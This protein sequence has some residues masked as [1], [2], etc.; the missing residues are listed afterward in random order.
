MDKFD[1]L[2]TTLSS[3]PPSSSETGISSEHSVEIYRSIIQHVDDYISFVDRDYRYLAVS[4]G[5]VNL[6]GRAEADIVGR[7]VWEL[8]GRERFETGLKPHLD[9]T[10]NRGEI[11]KFRAQIVSAQGE[12]RQIETEFVPYRNS[13]GEITGVVVCARNVTR[14]YQA[15][16]ALKKESTLSQLIIDSTPDFVFFKDING[17]YQRCNDAFQRFVCLPEQDIIGRSD[18]DLMQEESANHIRQRDQQVLV[19]KEVCENEEWVTYHNSRRRLLNMTKIPVFDDAQ[20]LIGLLGIGRDITQE[21]QG[22]S[23][24]A[25]AALLFQVTSDPCLILAPDGIIVDANPVSY[26]I[27]GYEANS[28]IGLPADC[29][30]H[31]S[32]GQPSL[33]T[34]LSRRSWKGEMIGILGSGESKPFLVALN[35]VSS[36]SGDLDCHVITLLDLGEVASF[37]NAL[38]T[39]AYHDP[40]TGLPN[41]LLLTSRLE[42]AI[43]QARRNDDYIAV[44]FADLDQFKP[45][46]DQYGHD[47]GD[48]VL[49]EVGRRLKRPLR[50]SDTLARL[51]GD[52]FVIVL[53]RLERIDAVE[54][55]ANK[56]LEVINQSAFVMDG[57]SIVMTV[58]IGIAIFPQHGKSCT[59]LI[60]NSDSAM[61]LAK[62]RG[63][64]QTCFFHRSLASADR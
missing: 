10:L 28:I 31:H 14:S 11:G 26:R 50:R 64:N 1:D 37:S 54:R 57:A 2:E 33:N 6:F 3:G 47:V 8:H 58:S 30:L 15:E 43:A 49:K 62:A 24:R 59:E 5:Y 56:L 20:R 44:L 40:L 12:N 45:V 42:H 63:A 7:H 32:P 18:A 21:R 22:E 38:S 60:K 39:K 13:S 35:S 23:N 16:Q 25:R 9:K 34:V 55:V 48:R 53:E 41:R 36:Q 52:E 27:F 4:R 19:T 46:N 61:Y 17:I 29:L 51:G